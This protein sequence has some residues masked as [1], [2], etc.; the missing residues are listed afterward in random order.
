MHQAAATCDAKGVISG[1]CPEVCCPL[2][3]RAPI[4]FYNWN[5]P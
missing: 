5:V 2:L 3:D 4:T 1:N